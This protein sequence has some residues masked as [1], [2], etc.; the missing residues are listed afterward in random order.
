MS[1]DACATRQFGPH[2]PPEVGWWS[3]LARDWLSPAGPPYKPAAQIHP[4]RR[5]W[6]GRISRRRSRW[7]HVVNVPAL[8]RAMWVSRPDRGMYYD[9]LPIATESVFD[10]CLDDPRHSQW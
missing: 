5:I 4:L 7:S 6:L 9:E 2:F 1:K 10:V 8:K 3:G